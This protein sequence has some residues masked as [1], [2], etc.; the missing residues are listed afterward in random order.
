MLKL[1][2]RAIGLG[3][4]GAIIVPIGIFFAVIVLSDILYPQCGTPGDSGGCAMGAA[5]IAYLSI[6]PGLVIGILVAIYQHFKQAPKGGRTETTLDPLQ[7]QLRERSGLPADVVERIRTWAENDTAVHR[8]WLIG[9]RGRGDHN[10]G[11][12]VEIALDLYYWDSPDPRDG[13]QAYGSWFSHNQ[14]WRKELIAITLL[15]IKLKWLSQEEDPEA[16][17]AVP[18]DALL[19]YERPASELP[20]GSDGANPG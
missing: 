15:P 14:R 12:D 11:D 2:M 20:W 3:L 10:V 8:V 9:A 5:G 7:P 4:F 6:I 13:Q 1:V 18:Q 16:F 17:F 19:I